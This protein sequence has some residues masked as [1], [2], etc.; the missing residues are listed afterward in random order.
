MKRISQL[1]KRRLDRDSS[2]ANFGLW[3]IWS[4][5][6]MCCCVRWLFTNSFFCVLSNNLSAVLVFLHLTITGSNK[7]CKWNLSPFRYS[8]EL[9]ELYLM[10]SHHTAIVI[11]IYALSRQEKKLPMVVKYG[12]SFLSAYKIGM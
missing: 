11:Q 4:G 2:F 8:S 7:L 10:V 5:L 9:T 3:L 6:Q 1:C 12:I